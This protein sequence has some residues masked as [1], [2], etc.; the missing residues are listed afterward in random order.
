MITTLVNQLVMDRRGLG[1]DF[2]SMYGVSVGNLIQKFS[3]M[4]RLQSEAEQLAGTREQMEELQREKYELEQE[5]LRLKAANAA[6][7]HNVDQSAALRY[8][9]ENAS[10]RALL[11][12]SRNTIALLQGSLKDRNDTNYIDLPEYLSDQY[13]EGF[14]NQ[15]NKLVLGN[16]WK[17]SNRM[18]QQSVSLR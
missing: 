13:T 5:V 14:D 17:T 16:E 9:T 12:T 18:S 1:D 7:P 2:S 4:D 10:L 6:I 15:S 8:A 11:R 3:D